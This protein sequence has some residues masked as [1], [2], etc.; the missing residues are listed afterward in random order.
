MTYIV[1]IRAEVIAKEHADG[2]KRYETHTLEFKFEDGESA[3]IFLETASKHVTGFE[4]G[5]IEISFEEGEF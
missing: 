1:K 4:A 5:H 3:L 2:S